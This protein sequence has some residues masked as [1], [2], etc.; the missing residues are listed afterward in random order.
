M[1]VI[2]LLVLAVALA[3]KFA[4]SRHID[5]LE[6]EKA[7]ADNEHSRLKSNLEKAKQRRIDSEDRLRLFE[8]E[9]KDLE[10][11]LEHVEGELEEI[12]ARNEE[13]EDPQ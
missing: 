6:V 9:K 12:V 13:L 7:A 8:L 4:T 2:T 5:A 10:K 1:E 11:Q 3:V